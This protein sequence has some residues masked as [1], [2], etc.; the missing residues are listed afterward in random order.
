MKKQC[1]IICALTGLLALCL[2]AACGGN[3]EKETSA[4][5]PETSASAEAGAA[6]R[7]GDV[8][9]LTHTTAP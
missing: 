1:K 6:L 2:L 7:V 5:A 4:A 3:T 9:E 8:V